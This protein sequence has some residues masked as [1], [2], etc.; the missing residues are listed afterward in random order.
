VFNGLRLTNKEKKES[1]SRI[2]EIETPYKGSPAYDINQ[3]I[4][5]RVYILDI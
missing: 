5:K 3:V 4:Q 2:Q 1:H